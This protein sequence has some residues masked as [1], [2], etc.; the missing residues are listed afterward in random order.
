[1][2]EQFEGEG[3][4][5]R[6]IA[7]AMSAHRGRR[8]W[9]GEADMALSSLKG[10]PEGEAK[11]SSSYGGVRPRA[12]LL[13]EDATRTNVF[14]P[15]DDD[16]RLYTLLK[17][18]DAIIVL[19][20]LRGAPRRDPHSSPDATQPTRERR[21]LLRLGPRRER[22]RRVRTRLHPARLPARVASALGLALRVFRRPRVV[23][24]SSLGDVSPVRRL[25][26]GHGR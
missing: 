10:L 24:G 13:K 8:R 22:A 16:V 15:V 2:I 6:A 20:A 25:A 23:L 14:R 19:V 4:L 1:M 18:E 21:A 12:H 3:E 5:E 26:L 7:I 17:L 9:R 11:A